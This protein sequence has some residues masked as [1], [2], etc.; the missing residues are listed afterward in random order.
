MTHEK[1]EAWIKNN[2]K[3]DEI[4][5]REGS[6]PRCEDYWSAAPFCSQYQAV[7]DK[8]AKPNKK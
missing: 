4:V 7:K 3:G 1:A 5:F 2:K 6:Y 8:A